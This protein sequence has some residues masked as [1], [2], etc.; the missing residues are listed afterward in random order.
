ML[1]LAPAIAAQSLSVSFRGD[2]GAVAEGA[3]FP[4]LA[5]GKLVGTLTVETQAREL[6]Y[7]AAY[8]STNNNL[9]YSETGASAPRAW[10]VFR[11]QDRTLVAS[12]GNPMLFPITLPI[13]EQGGAQL[14]VGSFLL[15][16]WAGPVVS[17][18]PFR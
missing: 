6:A 18:Q 17:N 15:R 7:V 3:T 1:L 11:A 2:D 9:L 14:P 10:F 13:G 5:T 8:Y 12:Q 16:V 4:V